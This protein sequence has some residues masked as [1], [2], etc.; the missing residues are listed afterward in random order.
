M[1]RPASD[2]AIALRVVLA[3]LAV[4]ATQVL[5]RCVLDR[6]QWL[7]D[8]KTGIGGSDAAAILG[9]SPWKT[10]YALWLEKCG[11]VPE[12]EES[13]RMRLGRKLEG[14]VADCYME[15]TRRTLIPAQPMVRSAERPHVFGNCDRWIALG[16]TVVGVWEGKTT[17]E[18]RGGDWEREPPVH[19][20]I[21]LQQYMYVM[22][23]PWGSFGVLIGGQRFIWLDVQR[24]DRFLRAY[25][26]RADEFW[27]RVQNGDPPPAT[28]GP[29]ERRALDLLYA[30]PVAGRAVDLQPQAVRWAEELEAAKRRAREAKADKEKYE[31]LLRAQIGE[32]TYARLPDGSGYKLEVETRK[33]H[34]RPAW[35]GRVLRRVDRLPGWVA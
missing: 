24:N 34:V 27:A 22:E 9:V 26:P 20:M 31:T 5:G 23:K 25:L 10:A 17:N 14:V 7:A 3:I 35:E 12:P 19:Y 6:A 4:L 8:R 16:D 15:E 28:G 32:A 29:G 1:A 18:A 2:D 13:E 33:E 11:L 30:R 21:Q